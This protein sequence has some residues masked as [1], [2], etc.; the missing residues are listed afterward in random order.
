MVY[1]STNIWTSIVYPD[2]SVREQLEQVNGKAD[3]YDAGP[4]G[5]LG[6][7]DDVMLDTRTFHAIEDFYD[8]GGDASSGTPGGYY[9]PGW[10]SP[11]LER[12]HYIWKIDK[13]YRFEIWGHGPHWSIEW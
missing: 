9:T 5:T 3:I 1:S 8:K 7:G 2:G 10:Y 4:D 12:Y 6:T 11:N 13:V